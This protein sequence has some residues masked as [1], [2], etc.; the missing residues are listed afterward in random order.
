MLEREDGQMVSKEEDIVQFIGAYFDKLFTTEPG[1]REAT[2]QKALHPIVTEEDNTGLAA[3]PSA[4]EI[5]EAVFAINAD[6]APVL[7]A[8]RQASFTHIGTISD[9]TSPRKYMRSL[10]ESLCHRT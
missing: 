6:K 9:L 1:E 10:W 3:T 7:M 8:F 2:V 4:L 5:K